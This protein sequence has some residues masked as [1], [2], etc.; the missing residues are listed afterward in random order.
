MVGCETAGKISGTPDA[1]TPSAPDQS[2][3]VGGGSTMAI[4]HSTFWCKVQQSPDGC[5]VWTAARS[6]TGYGVFQ[7]H[8]TSQKQQKAHR[9]A[10]Q[11]TYGPIPPRMFVC[12]HCDNRLCVRPDHLFL[13]TVLENNRDAVRKNRYQWQRQTHCKHGHEFTP[14]TIY[15]RPTGFRVCTTCR[16]IQKKARYER[17]K[18]KRL[19]ARGVIAHE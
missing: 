11:L 1:I 16:R 12:H 2:D 8:G 5:W 18:A 17:D 6:R 9:V 13:G 10:W 7:T 14:D 4:S 15:V 3:A 19:A